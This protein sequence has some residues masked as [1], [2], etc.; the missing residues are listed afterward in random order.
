MAK[1]DTDK[2]ITDLMKSGSDDGTGSSTLIEITTYIRPHQA[3]A[4]EILENAERQRLGKDFDR[5]SLIQEALDL[6]IEKHLAVVDLR[7]DKPVKKG[8]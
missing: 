8:S 3:F 4:L 6:L 1:E 5:A 7:K 2:A